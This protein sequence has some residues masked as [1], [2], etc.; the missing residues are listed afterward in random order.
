MVNYPYYESLTDVDKFEAYEDDVCL[1]SFPKAGR[2][3]EAQVHRF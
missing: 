2:H 3:T 1:I